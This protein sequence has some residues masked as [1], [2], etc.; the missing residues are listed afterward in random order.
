MLRKRNKTVNEYIHFT[1]ITKN[2]WESH[3]QIIWRAS[4]QPRGRH[5]LIYHRTFWYLPNFDYQRLRVPH[6]GDWICRIEVLKCEHKYLLFA[7]NPVQ[8]ISL[9]QYLTILKFRIDNTQQNNHV[10]YLSMNRKVTLKSSNLIPIN[11]H[12]KASIWNIWTNQ[13]IYLFIWRYTTTQKN[14]FLRNAPHFTYR[15]MW[16]SKI[17]I[18]RASWVTPAVALIST[19]RTPRHSAINVLPERWEWMNEFFYPRPESFD[20]S[21]PWFSRS[22]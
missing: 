8:R 11:L 9:A 14:Q 15:E 21:N 20:S 22:I 6:D 4:T 17:K 5:L 10:W 7:N 2:E 13:L 19:D 3:W 1:W 18:H 12:D 16:L